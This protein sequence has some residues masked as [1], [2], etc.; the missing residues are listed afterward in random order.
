MY[1]NV[2]AAFLI[3][4]FGHALEESRIKLGLSGLNTDEAD[5]QH[6]LLLRTRRERT[7]SRSAKKRGQEFSSSDVACHVTL[8]LGVIHGGR[9]DQSASRTGS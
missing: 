9:T 4:Q 5:P 7:R 8:R 2:I 1:S 6:F 3:A